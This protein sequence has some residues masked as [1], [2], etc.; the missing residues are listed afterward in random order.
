M[1]RTGFPAGNISL[2]Y[3]EA[4]TGKTTIAIQ[5]A[6]NVA[7]KGFKVIF[8]DSDN[9]FSSIRLSQIA[10]QDVDKISQNIVIFSPK[11]FKE[12]SHLIENLDNYFTPAVALVI[13]DTISSLYRMELGSMEETFA[14]NRELNR[15]LAYLAQIAKE[16][17][18]A[19]ML[20][21]QVYSILGKE[22]RP[23]IEPVA[24]RVLK[25]WSKVIVNLKQT[26]RT[27]VREAVLEK[28]LGMSHPR[29]RCYFKL[30]ETGIQDLGQ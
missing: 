11:N 27:G 2:I 10:R 22:Q 4:D 5:C 15:Q 17:R 18:I 26:P 14:L 8:I 25:F 21:S 28:F 30:T 9:T 29:A 3:G 13:I 23:E 7:R 19:V 24:V 12:Q 1:L 20:A 16:R 6:V